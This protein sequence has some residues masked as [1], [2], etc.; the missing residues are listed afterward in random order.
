MNR[1]NCIEQECQEVLETVLDL[2]AAGHRHLTATGHRE[3]TGRVRDCVVHLTN[4]EYGCE[5]GKHVRACACP[6][7]GGLSQ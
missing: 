7:E 1:L 3:L 5:T 2:M 6:K 4:K